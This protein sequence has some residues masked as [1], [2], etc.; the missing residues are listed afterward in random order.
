MT[1]TIYH[2]FF[3][4]EH[5]FDFLTRDQIELELHFLEINVFFKKKKIL[6]FSVLYII[7]L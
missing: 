4:I 1:R 3:E 6:E 7:F 2:H 5:D